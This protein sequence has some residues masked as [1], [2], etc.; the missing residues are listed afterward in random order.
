MTKPITSKK[1]ASKAVATKRA[2]VQLRVTG[3]G[4]SKFP[5]ATNLETAVQNRAQ[6]L[7]YNEV[8]T[9]SI[10]STSTDALKLINI[11]ANDIEPVRLVGIL[12]DVL[13][14]FLNAGYVVEFVQSAGPVRTEMKFVR[15]TKKQYKASKAA[16]V[17]KSTEKPAKAAKATKATKATKPTT[18]RLLGRRSGACRKIAREYAKRQLAA[19]PEQSRSYLASGSNWA[20]PDLE[21]TLIANYLFAAYGISAEATGNKLTITASSSESLE[22]YDP[23]VSGIQVARAVGLKNDANTAMIS[24][25]LSAHPGIYVDSTTDPKAY[26]FIGPEVVIDQLPQL[27]R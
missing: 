23:M 3:F 12:D 25:W 10:D 2:L 16:A 1:E 15:M 13:R 6:T 24:A 5:S 18:I 17:A 11:A 8:G 22:S 14:N 19:A 20:K 27:E 4:D 21:A 26:F 7:G 9:V